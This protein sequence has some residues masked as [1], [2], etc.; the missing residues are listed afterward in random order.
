MNTINA[1]LGILSFI[2]VALIIIGTILNSEFE[3]IIIDIYDGIV[4]TLVGIRVFIIR[5][6]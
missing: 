1:I 6:K 2:G 4:F 3:W 5:M